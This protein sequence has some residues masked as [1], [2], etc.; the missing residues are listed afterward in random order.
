MN[1]NLLDI[2]YLGL[3]FQLSQKIVLPCSSV[4][5]AHLRN[6]QTAHRDVYANFLGLQYLLPPSSFLV[7]GTE[8]HSV[9]A[10]TANHL[11]ASR[12]GIPTNNG[13][14]S[15]NNH[16]RIQNYAWYFL[17]KNIREENLQATIQL[18]LTCTSISDLRDLNCY[19]FYLENCMTNVVPYLHF[20]MF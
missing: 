6:R 2:D 13:H 14:A 4:Y 5:H 8:P 12:R 3:H 17:C 16:V 9:E 15:F 11:L 18:K 20:I 10:A 7:V 19:Y 1:T